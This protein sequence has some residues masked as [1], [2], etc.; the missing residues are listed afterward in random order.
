LIGVFLKSSLNVG[1]KSHVFAVYATLLIDD[2][3]VAAVL[4]NKENTVGLQLQND[5]HSF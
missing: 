5:L 2:T 1:F 4:S 3:N